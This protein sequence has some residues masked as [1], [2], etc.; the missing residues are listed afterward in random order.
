[1]KSIIYHLFC[2]IDHGWPLK[3][4]IYF[5][6]INS[7]FLR[8]MRATEL[9]YPRISNPTSLIEWVLCQSSHE[10]NQIFKFSQCLPYQWSSHSSKAQINVML[11]I[12]LQISIQGPNPRSNFIVYLNLFCPT[13]SH[14]RLFL[15]LW[16]PHILTLF[17]KIASQTISRIISHP[18]TNSSLQTDFQC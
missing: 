8:K 12:F 3:N 18:L 6:I 16:I 14:F 4:L 1:L 17:S 13:Y 5:L 9:I 10:Q 15:Y 2:P 11:L 7:V